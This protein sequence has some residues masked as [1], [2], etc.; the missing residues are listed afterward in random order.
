VQASDKSPLSDGGH[1]HNFNKGL[2]WVMDYI[3]LMCKRMELAIEGREIKLLA[4]LASLEANK[5]TR[6]QVDDQ[7]DVGGSG[8]GRDCYLMAATVRIISWNVRYLK[9]GL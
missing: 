8:W 3:I 7:F 4:F 9:E 1:D 5:K 6:N 2:A